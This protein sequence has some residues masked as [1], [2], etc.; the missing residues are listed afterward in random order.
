MRLRTTAP[1][2]VFTGLLNY[3]PPETEKTLYRLSEE[4]FSL[5]AAGSETTTVTGGL[6][7]P[8]PLPCSRHGQPPRTYYPRRNRP[9]ARTADGGVARRR[10]PGALLDGAGEES[11]P[12]GRD[13]RRFA[14][15]MWPFGRRHIKRNLVYQKDK[16]AMCKLYPATVGQGPAGKGSLAAGQETTRADVRG[17]TT[18]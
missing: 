15:L 3:C 18:T 8:Y 16:F 4:E 10:S 1:A 2:G 11:I 6:T 13:L 7:Y 5:I 9:F 14:P 12:V 17:T